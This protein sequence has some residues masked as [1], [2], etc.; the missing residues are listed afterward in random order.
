MKKDNCEEN[1]MEWKTVNNSFSVDDS[2]SYKE[3]EV[4]I[5]GI[6]KMEMEDYDEDDIKESVGSI[7]EKKFDRW[8]VIGDSFYPTGLQTTIDTLKPGYYKI[9]HN[10][11][12]GRFYTVSKA[13]K[14]DG[15]VELP[16][17]EGNAIIEH[18]TEFWSQD[19]ID[20]YAKYEMLH[21]TGVLMYGPPGSGKTSIINTLI[22]DLVKVHK[23]LVFSLEHDSELGLY[24]EFMQQL[25]QIEPN[26]PIITIIEDMD[27]LLD[28]G[29]SAEKMLL[30]ILDGINQIEHVAY[31]GTTNY[32]ERLAER[33]INRPGR[34][35]RRFKI[36]YPDAFARKAFFEFKFKEEDLKNFDLK[37]IVEKTV[38]LTI[39]HCKELF[40]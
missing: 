30:N 2:S 18:V 4:E 32:P 27:G 28:G 31:I 19:I 15:L 25:R 21:K 29:R 1:P 40:I 34:F 23:G 10:N 24:S 5:I 26:R 22:K 16:I 8:E 33:L 36:G 38:G 39:S 7:N 6:T 35:D 9:G 17:K 3:E 12:N 13:I 37:E 14:T 20:R 11:N